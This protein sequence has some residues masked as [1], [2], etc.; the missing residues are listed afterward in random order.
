MKKISINAGKHYQ[1]ATHVNEMLVPRETTEVLE[2]FLVII[3][4]Q[5]YTHAHKH[6]ENEQLYYVISGK[7]L[8]KYRISA[9]NEDNF[10]M[11]PGD[12]IHVPRNT[13]HQIF[14]TGDTALHYLCVDGFVDGIPRDEPTWDDHYAAVIAQQQS[15]K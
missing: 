10:T 8:A 6:V 11:N 5:Q 14:C 13:E 12:V 15:A 9:G 1:F 7:G 3:D 2:A 4:P